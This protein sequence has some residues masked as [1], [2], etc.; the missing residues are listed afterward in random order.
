MVT[1]D[2]LRTQEKNRSFEEKKNLRFVTALDLD[3]MP[4]TGKK[5]EIAHCVRTYFWITL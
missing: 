2:M 4:Y 3:Q 5:S 1:Q